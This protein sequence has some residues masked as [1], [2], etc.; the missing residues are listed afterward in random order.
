MPV[1]HPS[2]VIFYQCDGHNM[3]AATLTLRRVWLQVDMKIKFMLLPQS[4]YCS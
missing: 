1:Y 3:F 2:S 4:T